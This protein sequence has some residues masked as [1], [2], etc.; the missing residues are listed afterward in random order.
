[1]KFAFRAVQCSLKSREKVKFEKNRWVIIPNH[2]RF[3]LL[4][5]MNER[6]KK[7]QNINE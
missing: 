1:M 5:C 3:H 6:N 7:N 2:I 4:W